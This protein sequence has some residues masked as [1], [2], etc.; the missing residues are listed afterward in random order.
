MRVAT[1]RVSRFIR[2]SEPAFRSFTKPGWN[3]F[4]NQTSRN[5]AGN[6]FCFQC[7]QTNEGT[8]CTTVGVCGKTPNV[9]TLQDLLMEQLKG[10]GFYQNKMKEQGTPTDPETDVFLKESMFSTLTNVD[11]DANRF[12]EFIKKADK[13][14]E[15]SRKAFEKISGGISIILPSATQVKIPENASEDDLVNLGKNYSVLKRKEKFG[16]DISGLQELVTYG[17]KGMSAYSDHAHVLGID[18]ASTDA[19][20][21]E[22]LAYLA[23]ETPD[24]NTLLGY[25]MKVG[26]T[27]IQVMKNLD[28]GAT[29]RYGHPEPTKVRT[30]AIAGKC[31]LVS[32]HDLRDLEN[33]LI[34]TEGKGINVYTHGELLPA[35]GYP[36][37]KK[38]KHLVGNYGGAWQ[39][40]KFDFRNFPGPIVITTNCIVEPRK[41]YQSR[42]YTRSVVGFPGVTHIPDYDF[43]KV[44]QQALELPAIEKDEAPTYTMTGFARNAVLANAGKVVDLVQ[45]GKIKHFFL[46]GGCDGAEGSR[47]YFKDLALGAPKDTVILT[48]AC[49]KYRFNKQFDKFG[50]IEGL[51]RLLDVGQ[52][53]DAYSAIQIASALANAFN[54]DVNGLPL[55][56]AISWFEQKAVAVLLSLLSL[57]I[58][59]IHLGP[60]L[61]AFVT[62]NM[63]NIL[64]EKFA[65]KPT[66]PDVQADLNAYLAKQ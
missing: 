53:N 35:H 23:N 55:S 39:E 33:I 7:E 54:T 20:V 24:A 60:T 45:A 18:D 43:S 10:I 27:N 61:P 32:G 44:V 51:P 6:M 40:Q 48:L 8:G 37:L 56:F 62:P 21:N 17:L 9:A 64:V 63:L 36:G 1:R 49:G 25:A 34:Q 5:Y 38:Y 31:I 3:N 59:N 46:I 50:D 41:S 29:T 52:C 16:A 28:E 30:S 65:I 42:I 12:V 66:N 26:S 2:L 11:F 47:S 58:R 4:L 13:Y 57:G 14:L 15:K 19:V 22:V